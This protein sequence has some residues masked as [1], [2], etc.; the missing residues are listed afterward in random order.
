M[1]LTDASTG[2][3]RPESAKAGSGPVARSDPAS[4][5]ANYSDTFNPTNFGAA[6]EL[7]NCNVDHE[8]IANKLVELFFILKFYIQHLFTRVHVYGL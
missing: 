7:P 3:L 8:I 6:R 2:A 1:V 4:R 5:L